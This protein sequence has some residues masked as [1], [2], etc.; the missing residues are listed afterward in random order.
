MVPERFWMYAA[1][2]E[3]LPLDRIWI[4]DE[5]GRFQM[6]VHWTEYSV[7]HLDRRLIRLS[8]KKIGIPWSGEVKEPDKKRSRMTSTIFTVISRH[9]GQTKSLFFSKSSSLDHVPLGGT[10]VCRLKR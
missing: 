10:P 1:K 8:P 2:I 7:H 5:G 3:A 4:V 9:S 6:D